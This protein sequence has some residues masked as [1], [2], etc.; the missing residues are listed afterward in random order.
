M[1]ESLHWMVTL[2]VLALWVITVS[3]VYFF[4]VKRHIKDFEALSS[5]ERAALLKTRRQRQLDSK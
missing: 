4:V 3:S 1:N 2:L 5:G